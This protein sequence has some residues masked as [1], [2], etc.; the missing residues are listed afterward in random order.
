MSIIQ[1]LEPKHISE[2]E[3][4][5]KDLYTFT[6]PTETINLKHVAAHKGSFM[7]GASPG[8]SIIPSLI[9]TIFGAYAFKRNNIEKV[10][11]NIEEIK[12]EREEYYQIDSYIDNSLSK[13]A[14]TDA[15][16]VLSGVVTANVENE[17]GKTHWE[18]LEEKSKLF[19]TTAEVL[20][21]FLQVFN[22]NLDYSPPTLNYCKSVENELNEKLL[23]PF[24]HFYK[25]KNI[26]LKNS[27]FESKLSFVISN[28]KMK[29]TL[30]EHVFIL[31]KI[32]NNKELTKIES[33]YKR[34]LM[35]TNSYLL[36][37]FNQRI[38]I[39]TKYYRNPSGHTEVMDQKKCLECRN[40]IL[41][42]D[43][44]ISGIMG[45]FKVIK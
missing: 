34:F 22:D 39:I 1:L 20:R 17:I 28:D 19:I 36:G 11:K 38:N 30:G 16:N 43:G 40:S 35:I 4:V 41:A 32:L 25:S 10:E 14:N 42:K 9:G 33:E 12:K 8:Y 26:K 21:E 24:K 45:I 2:L 31:R 44:I 29:L 18:K 7:V 3:L 6:P 5:T 27:D 15:F 13:I 37:K 23:F